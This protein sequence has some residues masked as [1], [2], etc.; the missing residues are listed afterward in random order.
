[1]LSGKHAQ[2][3]HWRPA[4][5]GWEGCTVHGTTLPASCTLGSAHTR[6]RSSPLQIVQRQ[7][8]VEQL[9]EAQQL[10]HGHVLARAADKKRGRLAIVVQPTQPALALALAITGGSVC[11]LTVH[12]AAELPDAQRICQTRAMA[13]PSPTGCAA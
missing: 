5:C 8:V 6:G 7:L 2:Q 10:A 4:L 13:A 1:M 3:P 11:A 9:G 12:S